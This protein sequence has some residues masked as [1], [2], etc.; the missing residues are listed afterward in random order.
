MTKLI[1]DDAP[2]LEYIP[3]SRHKQVENACCKQIYS[4]M[5]VN[6]DISSNL[7]FTT[8]VNSLSIIFLTRF[9]LLFT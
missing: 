2:V 5:P 7:Q 1:F 8:F 6:K 9:A 4:R 3:N